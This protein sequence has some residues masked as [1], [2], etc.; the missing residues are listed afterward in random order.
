MLV[1]SNGDRRFGHFTLVRVLKDAKQISVC[2]PYRGCV[3]E[4]LSRICASFV[5]KVYREKSPKV[6]ENE[7]RR[8]PPGIWKLEKE[9]PTNLNN[10][11]DRSACGPLCLERLIQWVAL[12]YP[13]VKRYYDIDVDSPPEEY[14]CVRRRCIR[15]MVNALAEHETNVLCDG[16]AWNGTANR[17]GLRDITRAMYSRSPA[18]FSRYFAN[19]SAV[20][21]HNSCI[22]ANEVHQEAPFVQ[23]LCCDA[24]H[25]M[26]CFLSMVVS[27]RSRPLT[28]FHCQARHDAV[29]QIYPKL[30]CDIRDVCIPP[31]SSFFSGKIKSLTKNIIFCIGQR[32]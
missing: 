4:R 7:G 24:A 13:S 31:L 32:N 11:T 22:C 9:S 23:A 16:L 1:V 6:I 18:N 5:E 3:P 29:R 2:D 17:P 19:S 25:H 28:C 26:H 30:D 10:T 12:S 15:Y 14:R 20:L 21:E 27:M 8:T